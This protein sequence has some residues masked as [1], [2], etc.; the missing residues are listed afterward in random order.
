MDE[1]RARKELNTTR[2]IRTRPLSRVPFLP[3][4]G[5]RMRS[6]RSDNDGLDYLYLNH[7]ASIARVPQDQMEDAGRLAQPAAARHKRRW[8]WPSARDCRDEL[9]WCAVV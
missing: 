8:L 3:L 4:R 6:A 7:R 5:L 1:R 9:D 2:R